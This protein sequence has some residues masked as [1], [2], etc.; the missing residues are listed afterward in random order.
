MNRAGDV[1]TVT[2]RYMCDVCGRNI[3]S[4]A[5]DRLPEC[6]GCR[7]PDAIWQLV[8]DLSWVSSPETEVL[9]R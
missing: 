1:T 6:S 3:I 5:G 7:Q 9:A 4:V 8:T 2:G